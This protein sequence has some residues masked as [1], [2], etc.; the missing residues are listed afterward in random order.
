MNILDPE[1][2]YTQSVKTDI[3]KIF[4]RAG[5]IPPSEDKEF[6]K[7]WEFYRTISIRNERKMK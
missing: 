5:W 2:P 3:S 4:R 1:V 6:Q 7:K